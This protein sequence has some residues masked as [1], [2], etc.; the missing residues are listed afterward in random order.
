[1]FREMRR[2][3]QEMSPAE[4]E[5]ILCS[6]FSGVLAVSGDEGYPYAVPLNFVYSN[7]FIYFHCALSGHKLDAIKRDDKCSFCVIGE[8][9]NLPEKF[10]ALYKSVIV[11]GRAAEV[12]DK[13][14]KLAAIDALAKKYSPLEPDES[15][16]KEIE[17]ALG[18]LN[19]VKI[20]PE[21]ITGKQSIEYVKE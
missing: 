4:C 12:S 20:T 18:R 1:M 21:H 11:F 10:T 5:S 15:R 9:H 17:G 19:M 6:A 2:K 3:K 8:E 14:E 7:G 13:A 16:K